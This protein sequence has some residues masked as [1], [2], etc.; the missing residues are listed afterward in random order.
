VPTEALIVE[1]G[2]IGNRHT[3]ALVATV[4]SIDGLLDAAGP[5]EGG[6]SAP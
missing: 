2:P 6:H 3:A 4:G 1:H 5:D